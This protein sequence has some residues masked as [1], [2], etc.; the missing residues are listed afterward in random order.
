MRLRHYLVLITLPA[1]ALAVI[2]LVALSK[3]FLLPEFERQDA[4]SAEQNAELAASAIAQDISSM[5]GIVKDW[6][7]WDETY[8][9]AESPNEAFAQANLIDSAFTN[10]QISL[11]VLVNTSGEVVQARGFDLQN[12][13][14]VDV[15]Q[16][17]LAQINSAN[18]LLSDLGVDAQS[19]LLLLPEG[20]LKIAAASILPS[21]LEG[22]SAGTLLI[23]RWLDQD[24]LVY[25]SNVIGLPIELL[26][27]P[28][29]ADLSALGWQPEQEDGDFWSKALNEQWI[30]GFAAVQDIYG[31]TAVVLRVRSPRQV[32]QN[33][34]ISLH[35]FAVWLAILLSVFT[36]IGLWLADRFISRRITELSQRI[37]N[38]SQANEKLDPLP[39]QGRDEI[40]EMALAFNAMLERI[41]RSEAD[42]LESE[43]RM[44]MI[45]ENLPVMAE[46]LDEHE[47]II[48]WNK[49]CEQVTGYSSEEILAHPHPLALLHPDPVYLD[50]MLR[51]SYADPSHRNM[52]WE[53]TCKDGTVK[54]IAYSNISRQCPIPGW[55]EWAIGMDISEQT[56]AL[57]ALRKRE[58]DFTTLV[59]NSP[60]L[61]VRYDTQLRHIYGNKAAE[62]AGVP[63]ALAFGKKASEQPISARNCG[64]H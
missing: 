3:I 20:T 22:P 33:S 64:S 39:V 47:R 38:I 5:D 2:S 32:Y 29:P 53:L 26:E 45:V 23:G 57:E 37:G 63:L 35:F 34:L 59:E 21:N 11:F 25:L 62:I 36:L 58:H 61:I 19:G 54:T 7:W 52:I 31:Q 28:T 49:E 43:Q 10:L 13:Q 9:A 16:S 4:L 17:L 14:R 8:Q 30:D 15:P 50:E 46:A 1:L 6:A 40:S 48:F 27:V 55:H 60:D 18:P 24:R 44:R 12:R 42:L 56:A 51:R 41:K